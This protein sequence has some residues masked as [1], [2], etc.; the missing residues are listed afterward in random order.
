MSAGCGKLRR[1]RAAPAVRS[2]TAPSP[3]QPAELSRRAALTG[4]AAGAGT[5]ALGGAP[6]AAAAEPRPSGPAGPSA[7]DPDPA[8]GP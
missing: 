1:P 5:L 2:T 8:P 6:A 4:L 3:H 7:A